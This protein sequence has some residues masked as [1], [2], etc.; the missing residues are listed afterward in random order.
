MDLELKTQESESD[1]SY[2][3]CCEGKPGSSNGESRETQD[4]CYCKECKLCKI[5]Q[6]TK[7]VKEIYRLRKKI[8]DIVTMEVEDQN[9]VKDIIDYLNFIDEIHYGHWCDCWY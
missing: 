2:D 1:S 6:N 5:H 4:G 8:L 3:S 9:K 7:S